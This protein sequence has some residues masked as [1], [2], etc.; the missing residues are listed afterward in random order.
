[1]TFRPLKDEE[2]ER[3]KGLLQ[4]GLTMK[5]VEEKTAATTFEVRKIRNSMTIK[6]K[7][8]YTPRKRAKRGGKWG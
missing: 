2:I 5:A 8:A 3:I 6:P 4:L 1:M 7:S